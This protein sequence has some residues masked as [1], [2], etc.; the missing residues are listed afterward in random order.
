M[1]LSTLSTSCPPCPREHLCLAQL[2]WRELLHSSVQNKAQVQT[3]LRSQSVLFFLLTGAASLCCNLAWKEKPK[4][5]AKG[6][7]KMSAAF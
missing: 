7:E 2:T 6:R 3:S 5:D 1:A 4:G